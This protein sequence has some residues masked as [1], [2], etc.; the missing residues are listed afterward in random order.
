[1]LNKNLLKIDKATGF[2][3]AQE[4]VRKYKEKYPHK[5]IISLG[6][7]DVSKPIVKPIIDAMHKAVDELSD[8]NSFSGYG[9]YYGLNELRE[10]ILKHE[11]KK[12]GF[13]SEEIFI[14]DGTKSDSTNIL[15][16][17]DI[18]SKI[19][20]P[21]VV[22]PIYRNGAYALNRK[23]YEGK[24]DKDFK[25]LIPDKHYDIIYICSPSNPIGNAYTYDDLKKWVKYC[26]KEKAILIIDNVYE[27]FINSKDIPRS[28]YEIKGAEKCAIEL[29]SFSKKAS[30]T[31]LRC[32]YFVL[33]KYIDKKY[34]KERTINRFNGASYI[35][36][37]G[38]IAFY[39]KE[40][41]ALIKK[42]IKI[43]EENIKYLKDSFI[44]LGFEVIGG[45]DSPYLWVKIKENIDSFSYTKKLLHDTNVVVVPGIIF[46]K[47][48]DR[49]F[50]VSGLGN[51]ENSKK[52]IKRLKEY[53][54]EKA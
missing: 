50:R 1:M 5:D 4:Y 17:F 9:S 27:C 6:I 28:I 41:Q 45:I 35:A 2:S 12:Y 44:S 42:N 25:M 49:Y 34:F 52:A 13:S 11:Y 51:I 33:P 54:E 18:K 16:L 47:K 30:F 21:E 8:M 24:L 29:R 40:A 53:Y 36:Q 22:Y 7:G 32:S 46:G 26:L 20:L 15:E 43:Y 3:A 23:V 37:K 10:T 48:G 31:G 39:T 38:A 14:S 19:L